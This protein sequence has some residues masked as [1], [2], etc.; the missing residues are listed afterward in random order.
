MVAN[1]SYQADVPFG[2][3][4][5]HAEVEACTAPFSVT[6]RWP[7][8]AVVIIYVTGEIDMLTEL[9]LQSSL[10]TAFATN[11]QRLI[12]DLSRVS[13]LGATGLSALIRAKQAAVE[14]GATLQLTIPNR[15]LVTRA[16]TTTGLDR[17]FDI[18]P[19]SDAWDS[20][21]SARPSE[22]LDAS[23]RHEM[24]C[25]DDGHPHYAMCSIETEGNEDEY[26]HLVPLQRRYAEPT[27]GTSATTEAAGAADQRL[28]PR[29][30]EHRPSIHRAR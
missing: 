3:N 20:A 28:S 18:L 1:R 9:S 19:S 22:R 2:P 17:L 29:G 13:F 23:R 24:Q 12:I 14:Q 21:D 27:C 7:T 25:R 30:Q 4:V 26:A 8:P 5:G 16:L 6:L 10:K 11:P 15:R